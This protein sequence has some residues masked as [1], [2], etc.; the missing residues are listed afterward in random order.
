MLNFKWLINRLKCMTIEEII[1]RAVKNARIM[2][3]S[4]Q[5]KRLSEMPIKKPEI[6][7]TANWISDSNFSKKKQLYLTA[8]NNIIKG[9]LSVFQ[10]NF[11]SYSVIRCWN[12]DPKTGTCAPMVFGKKLDYRKHSLV[13]DIKYLWEPNRHLHLVTLAQAYRF[14]KKKVYLK[15]LKLHISSWIEQCPYLIGPNWCSSLEVGIRLINWCIVWQMIGGPKSELFSDETG[16]KFQADWLGSIFQH[17][18]FIS[19]NLSRYSSANNHLIGEAAGL[20]IGANTWPY[21][22]NATERWRSVGQ[23]ILV[24]EAQK[25]SY[26]DGGTR[27]QAIA[28]QQFVLDF[29]ILSYLS[30]K[31]IGL[32]FPDS[33]FLRMEKMI[34]FL[35]FMSDFKGNLPMIGD[36]DDGLVIRIS[37]DPAFDPYESL[38]NTGA[39]LF[40][41]ND[42]PKTKRG[43]D[44]KTLWFISYLGDSIETEGKRVEQKVQAFSTSGYYI[45]GDKLKDEE[46]TRCIIDC[47]PLGYLSI[48]AHGHADALSI[49]LSI[50]GTEFLI[51]PGTYCYHTNQKWREYFRGT[52]AHNTVRIDRVNQSVSGGNFMWV[53]KANAKANKFKIGKNESI[54]EGEHDGYCRLRDPVI[55]QR[56]IIFK[57]KEKEFHIT[58]TVFCKKEHFVERFW[59]FHENCEV[60][61][62]GKTIILAKNNNLTIRLSTDKNIKIDLY[63]GSESLPLG[64]VSRKYDLKTPSYT[65]VMSQKIIGTTTLKT[66]VQI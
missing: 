65:A 18:S 40:K 28:Y 59:H 29:F 27:E 52:S 55:H 1:F 26:A 61:V 11:D 3:E 20:F 37:Q 21:W 36:A 24:Q 7:T 66:L 50:Q 57:K 30:G 48:A 4:Y 39:L 42:F 5:L 46:E 19:G 9:R 22:G 8:A 35:A 58:D 33:F 6:L 2:L 56:K 12:R 51:D 14:S 13:G 23:E 41:R 45:L 64:W 10:R 31:S 49:F 17:L 47:G 62:Q 53:N 32:F 63:K 25:Q 60:E 44:D 54:F 15:A 38:I 34:E 43:I 16:Q